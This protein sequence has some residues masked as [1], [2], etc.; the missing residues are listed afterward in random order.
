MGIVARHTRGRIGHPSR[1]QITI[2][3]H[4]ASIEAQL[5]YFAADLGV[6]AA[7]VGLFPIAGH[8]KRALH[9][10]IRIHEIKSLN[11][12]ADGCG[13]IGRLSDYDAI[14]SRSI[15]T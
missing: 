15:S 6:Y 10:E 7:L 14:D 3:L 12:F 8:T 13:A 5:G 2:Q 9:S 4:S 11:T 1:V